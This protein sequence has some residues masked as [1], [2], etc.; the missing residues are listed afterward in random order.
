MTLE[1]GGLGGEEAKMKDGNAALQNMGICE[2]ALVSRIRSALIAAFLV[3]CLGGNTL[4]CS[5]TMPGPRDQTQPNNEPSQ[6]FDQL[7]LTSR[8]RKIH[9]DP[10]DG[11][12]SYPNLERKAD[13][14]S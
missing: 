10:D 2:N 7:S 9:T 8:A 11:P 5:H 3:F 13:R 14:A 1:R 12:Y 6:S 4:D